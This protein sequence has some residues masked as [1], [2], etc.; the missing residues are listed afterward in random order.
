M[1]KRDLEKSLSSASSACDRSQIDDNKFLIRDCKEIQGLEATIATDAAPM[2]E[3]S[4][5]DKL[6]SEVSSDKLGE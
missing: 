3:P 5:G 4:K 2:D 6:H 1:R